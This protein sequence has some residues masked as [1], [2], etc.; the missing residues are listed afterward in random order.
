MLMEM[1]G[2]CHLQDLWT[3]VIRSTHGSGA[4]DFPIGIHLEARAKIS[5][6]DMTVLVNENVV[7]FDVPVQKQQAS[8]QL[9]K[10]DGTIHPHMNL[11]TPYCTYSTTNTRTQLKYLYRN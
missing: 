4:I 1:A 5:Q 2:D 7:W 10:G 9:A 11:R 8:K 6:S 3:D